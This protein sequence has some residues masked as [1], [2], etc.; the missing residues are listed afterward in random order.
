MKLNKFSERLKDAMNHNELN[1]R[2][3]AERLNTTQQTISRWLQGAN[4]PDFDTLL[5]I[6]KCLE[7]SPNYFLGYDEH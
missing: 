7:E 2:M 1:Q 3:L 5:R 6:C 4:E